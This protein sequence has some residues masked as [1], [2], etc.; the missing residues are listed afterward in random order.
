MAAGAARA[1][2]GG[3]VDALLIGEGGERARRFAAAWAADG[4]GTGQSRLLGTALWL[5]DAGLRTEPALAGAWF[6]GPDGAARARFEGRYREAFRETPPRI[7]AAAYDAAAI[8]ARALR[9]G[10]PVGVVTSAETFAGADGPVRLLP[11]GVTQRGLA[12]YAITP[13]GEPTLVEPAPPPG[14]PGS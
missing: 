8:A 1:A 13:S 11:G 3:Q 10:T 2:A 7:A 4:A 12:V 9:S 6:A 14:G 5:N